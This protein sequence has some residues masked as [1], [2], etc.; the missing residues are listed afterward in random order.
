[1]NWSYCAIVCARVF[2]HYITLPNQRI[3]LAKIRFVSYYSIQK[4]TK[5]P[6]LYKKFKTKLESNFNITAAFPPNKSY[7]ID[8]V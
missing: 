7:C 8:S 2:M 4:F 6:T 1:M 5:Q 3:H